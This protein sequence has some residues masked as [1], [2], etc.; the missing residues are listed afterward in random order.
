[1]I[2]NYVFA[3]FLSKEKKFLGTDNYDIY[4]LPVAE[5]AL[6]QLSLLEGN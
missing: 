1:M 3:V 2:E 6:L 4:P 5:N